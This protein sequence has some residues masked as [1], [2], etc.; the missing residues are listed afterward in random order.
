VTIDA[1][2]ARSVL[3]P[4]SIHGAFHVRPVIYDRT[5]RCGDERNI[6]PPR[7]S[8]PNKNPPLQHRSGGSHNK[9]E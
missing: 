7:L 9:R 1:F 8:R 3:I 4:S 2:A 5:A 6:P